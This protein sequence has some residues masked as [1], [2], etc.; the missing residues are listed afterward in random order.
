[1]AVLGLE[2]VAVRRGLRVEHHRVEFRDRH[3]RAAA[4]PAQ[5]GFEQEPAVDVDDDLRRPD[6]V[7][8]EDRQTRVSVLRDAD[9]ALEEQRLA[10]DGRGLRERH[11]QAP[12]QCRALRERDVVEGVAELVGQRRHRIEAAV[13]VHHHTTD[14][15]VDRRAVR[16][17]AFAV[18]DLGVDPVLGERARGEPGEIGG[19]AAERIEHERGGVVPRHFRLVADRREEV[20]PRQP[21]G[22]AEQPALGPEVATEVGQ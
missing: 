4:P 15:L 3:A 8:V 20:P 1:M 2:P 14:V 10:E 22:M 5:L 21:V 9:G 12:L 13:E 18:A 11:R 17:A 7:G 6:E 19:V 16:T